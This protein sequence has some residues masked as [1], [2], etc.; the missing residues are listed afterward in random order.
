VLPF[1]W[2]QFAYTFDAEL[3]AQLLGLPAGDARTAGVAWGRQVADALLRERDFD[4][5]NFGVDYRP[6]AGP[7]RWQPT[8]ALF[9][10][11]LLPQWAAV[12]PFALARADQFR[13]PPP[14]ALTSAEWAQQCNEVKALGGTNS[15]AR[16]P[17]QA[18]I[19]WFWADGQGTPT[20]PGRWNSVAAQLAEARALPLVETARLFA[21]VNLALADAGIACWDAKY[22]Y[23]WWR[24]VTAIRAAD[25]DG[26]PATEPDP[27]WTPLVSTPPFPEHVS[28]HSTFSA[29]A[30]AV[31][32]AFLG[33][34][35]FAFT[36]RSD[37]L[38]GEA[39]SYGRFSEAAAEAG[40]SRI[41]GGIH[42]SSA[43]VDGQALGRA[44]G[45]HVAA[46]YLLL[47]DAVRQP[48]FATGR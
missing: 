12:K 13:P 28:G 44:I 38:F 16:T 5:A 18:R 23:D 32:A 45:Q 2:P 43:N 14:P 29:A 21:L 48:P 15:A 1:V 40:I 20:P 41:Y 31:L 10:S 26:N 42:F 33:G 8:P 34:D 22:A 24:P 19:A 30:A 11:P 47:R 36:L 17:E 46:H 37:G 6:A 3:S 7:G 25:T 27:A 4:G 9:A 39:R 35:E